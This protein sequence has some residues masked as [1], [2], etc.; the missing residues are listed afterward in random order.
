MVDMH[1]EVTPADVKYN[2]INCYSVA[3]YRVKHIS[4]PSGAIVTW[5]DE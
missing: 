1:Y 4:V 2:K 5:G 3:I